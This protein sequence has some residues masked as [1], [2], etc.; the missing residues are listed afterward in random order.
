MH[1]LWG[2]SLFLIVST[3]KPFIARGIIFLALIYVIYLFHQ[4]IQFLIFFVKHILIFK[5]LFQQVIPYT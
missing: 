5:R 3:A 2:S 4:P 1:Y